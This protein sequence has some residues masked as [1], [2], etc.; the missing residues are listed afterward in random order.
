METT[1]IYL[2]I[3]YDNNE[4]NVFKVVG[5]KMTSVIS[6]YGFSG[7]LPWQIYGDGKY[8]YVLDVSDG[9]PGIYVYE[10]NTNTESLNY[11]T[12]NSEYF[13]LQYSQMWGDDEFIYATTAENF[14]TNQTLKAYKLSGGTL[15][16]VGEYTGDTFNSY[17]S[18]FVQ[19]GYIFVGTNTG[20]WVLTFNGTEFTYI[21]DYSV[22]TDSVAVNGDGTHIYLADWGTGEDADST[23]FAFSFDGESLTEITSAGVSGQLGNLNT[24]WCDS[25]GIIWMSSGWDQYS[26]F[27]L[28]YKLF[29]NSFGQVR[30]LY[31]NQYNEGTYPI[32]IINDN[33]NYY[34]LTSKDIRFY[35][36]SESQNN[37]FIERGFDG[38]VYSIALQPDGK[39]LVGGDFTHYNGEYAGR[40]IRLNSDGSIDQGFTSGGDEFNNSV[41]AIAVQNDGKI[42]VGG[43][44][45]SYYYYSCNGYA[46]LNS[47]GTFDTTFKHYPF[48]G[49]VYSILLENDNKTQ[50]YTGVDNKTQNII[51]GG[52]FGMSI[53]ELEL[54]LSCLSKFD[55]D[56]TFINTYENG[57]NSAYN[58]VFDM[59]K[60]SDGKLI[61]VGGFD[62]YQ[63]EYCP[64]NI[65]RINTDGSQDL[66][67]VGKIS[68]DGGGFNDGYVYSIQILPNGKIMIGSGSDYFYDRNDDYEN[69]GFLVRLNSNG[70]L[71]TTF[72]YV[73]DD[74]YVEKVLLRK[75]KTLLVGGDFT[76][77][78]DYLLD[79]FIGEDFQLRAFTTCDGGTANIY[80]PSTFENTY[81]GGSLAPITS[82]DYSEITTGGLDLFVDGLYDDDYWTV[83]FPSGFSVNFLQTNYTSV[84]VSS[85][86]YITFGDP[87]IGSDAGECC[88]DI[89]DGIP[90][91]T[92]QPGVYLSFQ[93]PDEFGN[94]D[95]ELYE[96][97]SGLTDG[98]NTMVIKYVGSDHCDEIATL[99]YGFRFYKDEPNYFDL[100]IEENT[101]FFNDNPTGGVSNGVDPSWVS[102]FDSS[103]LKAYRIS[104]GTIKPIK[105][106]I[107]TSNVVCGQVGDV[108]YT[109]QTGTTG[110]PEYF[111]STDTDTTYDSCSGCT[112]TNLYKTKL[113]VR[114]GGVTPNYVKNVLMTYSDIQN[115]LTNGPIFTIVRPECYEILTYN[116]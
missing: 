116:L 69:L 99:I 12:T 27:L 14:E 84:N 63:G 97:Y 17:N 78:Y 59:K 82:I 47:D 96:L 62:E 105:A 86:P 22:T 3:R 53:P 115:V 110:Q 10:F 55:P 68:D 41:Y 90:T 101:N 51:I 58:G 70:T 112:E 60:Q 107:N 9:S 73:L 37:Y 34:I 89:P 106:D 24:I 67:F 75:D 77:P 2:Y 56:G 8:L 50:Y 5:N 26:Y 79:M 80:L 54:S 64:W 66:S 52:D 43:D 35:N 98:G 83:G 71:D 42:V 7:E 45:G 88:F 4:I 15:S 33:V 44:F 114:D 74:D 87:E 30:D 104:A 91:S 21:T 16:V 28:G 113:F 38:D 102:T 93:C 48:E 6:N 103:S 11:I 13:S 32:G 111:I 65:I 39:I 36:L 85:N 100:I 57:F 18:V 49:T 20:L 94:Y 23:L 31:F 19:N 95:A 25:E 40:I 81:V 92:E 29:G 61:C 109:P 108:I 76:S 46:R 72:T 1:R